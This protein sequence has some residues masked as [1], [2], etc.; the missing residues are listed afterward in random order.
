[1]H[2]SI[3]VYTF[4]EGLLSPLAHDLLLRL[5]RFEIRREGAQIEADLE[6]DSFEVVGIVRGGQLEEA[7]LG[8]D[9]KAKILEHLRREVLHTERYPDARFRGSV[10]ESSARER[11]LVGQLTLCGTSRALELSLTPRSQ[12]WQGSLELVPSEFG[13]RPFRALGGA[14]KVKDRVRVVLEAEDPALTSPGAAPKPGTS[15]RASWRPGP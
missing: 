14:L 9:D 8:A 12:R 15:A 2:A 1:M 11:I 4:K 13:I 5:T 6:P 10:R 7:G 3:L